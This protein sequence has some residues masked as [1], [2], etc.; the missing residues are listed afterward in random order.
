[1]AGT[2]FLVSTPIGNLSDVSERALGVLADVDV[3]YAEDTR[4]TG[5]MLARLGLEVPLRSLHGHNEAARVGEIVDRLNRGE[6]CALVSD[7]GTPAISDPGRAVVTAVHDA[8]LP[9]VPIPGPSA[10]TAALAASGLPA[11]RFL[12]LGFAPRRGSSRRAWF[13]RALSSPFTV[14][15]FESPRRVLT[16]L[17][18]FVAAGLAERQCVVC[19]ELT[20][21]HEDIVRGTVAEVGRRLDEERLRGEITLVL[22]GGEIERATPQEA[23]ER[24]AE[25]AAA[26]EGA[27]QIASRL[28]LEFRLARNEAYRCALQ[29][30]QDHGTS[31]DD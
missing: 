4:H 15:V 24:A 20:K 31:I 28:Q 19:R 14:V 16:L 17:E 27:R 22:E 5:R 26:G 6:R 9:V 12:F 29:A 10:V 21:L 11:D 30:I 8:G 2:L 3:C 18:D 13:D 23:D 1:M 25:L 7:A